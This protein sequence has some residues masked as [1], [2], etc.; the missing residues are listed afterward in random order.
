[1]ALINRISRLFKADL[2][3]VLDNIEEPE[4][5][6]KQ[7]VREMEDD[8]GA[9]EQNL[10]N[11]HLERLNLQTSIKDIN[12]TLEK[13]NEEL[14]I[15]FE[16]NN[17]ELAHRLVRRKLESER[18][19]DFIQRKHESLKTRISDTTQR[20]DENRKRLQS[21][22]QKLELFDNNTPVN[23]AHEFHV[24]PS[25]QVEKDEVDVAFLREKQQRAQS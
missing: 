5:L 24:T 21:M 23:E 2:H 9:D 8:L 14:D 3:A 18:C 25:F 10:K 16:S 17:D 11:L 20:I 19:R 1:M 7:S 22:Q 15:C 6:L 13:A 4:S 12:Q